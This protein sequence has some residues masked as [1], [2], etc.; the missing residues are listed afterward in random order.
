MSNNEVESGAWPNLIS[1]IDTNLA[2]VFLHQPI[3]D[4]K[5]LGLFLEICFFVFVKCQIQT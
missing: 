5:S 2:L 1:A 4:N 3:I